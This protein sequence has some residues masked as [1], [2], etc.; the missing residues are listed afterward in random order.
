MIDMLN[1]KTLDECQIIDLYGFNKSVRQY[2]MKSLGN[3]KAGEQVFDTYGERA[4][5]ELV[6]YYG[7]AEPYITSYDFVNIYSMITYDA[8][9]DPLYLQK[10]P[11]FETTYLPEVFTFRYNDINIKLK[12]G[13][14][15]IYLKENEFNILKE[16]LETEIMDIEIDLQVIQFLIKLIKEYNNRFSTTLEEDDVLL[17]L[18]SL[19]NRQ[20]LALHLRVIERTIMTSILHL[21][22]RQ[23]KRIK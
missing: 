2:Q 16:Y 8:Q 20:L 18:K 15:L 11:L 21:L 5:I 3:Y 12:A 1:H 13:L 4:S 14:R 7:F 10:K 6:A 17:S 23:E 9:A 19:S 22:K